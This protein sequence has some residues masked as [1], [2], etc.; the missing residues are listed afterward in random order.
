MT[1]KLYISNFI[2]I[3]IVII[4][5]NRVGIT[6]YV[7]TANAEATIHTIQQF[8]KLS[9]ADLKLKLHINSHIQCI[10]QNQVKSPTILLCEL[11]D[12]TDRQYY[13]S[14]SGAGVSANTSCT[15]VRLSD[16]NWLQNVSLLTSTGCKRIWHQ[17]ISFIQ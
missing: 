2:Q 14:T 4:F 9:Y 8:I 10:L 3:R 13:T 11:H 5:S 6:H 17:N 1:R 15:L 7:M 16:Q 12:P